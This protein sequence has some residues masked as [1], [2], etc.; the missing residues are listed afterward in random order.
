MTDPEERSR[1]VTR[2][3]PSQR[4]PIQIALVFLFR[5]SCDVFG[6][7]TSPFFGQ[8]GIAVAGSPLSAKYFVSMGALMLAAGAYSVYL[9][10]RMDA[11]DVG[12]G[13]LFLI[14][15][16][17]TTTAWWITDG[18]DQYF[19]FATIFWVAVL[20]LNTS[21]RRRLPVWSGRSAGAVNLLSLAYSGVLLFLGALLYQRFGFPMSLGFD[22]AYFRRAAFNEWLP[23]GI[24]VYLF[25]WS[26]YVFCAYLLFVP[27]GW[28]YKLT[29]VIF[30]FLFFAVSG[31]KVYALILPVFIFIW[32]VTLYNMSWIMAPVMAVGLSFSVVVFGLGDVWVSTVAQRLMIMPADI[33]FRYVGYFKEPLLYSYS[34]LSSIFAYEFGELPGLLI[35]RLFYNPGDNATATFTSDMFVNLGWWGLLPLVFF[36]YILRRTLASGVHLVLLLPFFIQ[37]IDTPLPTALLTGGGGL[38]I[39]GALLI[40][41]RH[42]PSEAGSVPNG[43]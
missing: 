28:I 24:L 20:I 40:A 41:R 37:L 21:A 4:I 25:S 7:T 3:R 22:T 15:Y 42:R 12:L 36:F 13:F 5:F 19:W 32:I 43:P 30:I 33:S 35:G 18:S 2:L 26:V 11:F 1:S 27:K 9:N 38:M 34:F 39:L 6:W 31:N 29:A 23:R 10:R 17:P 14:S 8:Y 16:V